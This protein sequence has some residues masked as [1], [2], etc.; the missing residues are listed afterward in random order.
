MEKCVLNYVHEWGQI[1]L[2]YR[3]LLLP[4]GQSAFVTHGFSSKLEPEEA[5]GRVIPPSCKYR[6]GDRWTS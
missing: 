6:E 4:L 1:R 3:Y 2:K 5:H